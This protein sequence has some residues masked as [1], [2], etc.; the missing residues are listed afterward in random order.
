MLAKVKLSLR[1]KTDSLDDDIQD[2]I[3]AGK[4]SIKI[5]W[6]RVI[7]EDDPLINQALKIYCKAQIETDPN[8][9]ERYMQSFECLKQSL[10]LSSEYR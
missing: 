4:K 8:K 10:S 6:V 2:Y 1:I 5:S 3:N 7:E 9:S